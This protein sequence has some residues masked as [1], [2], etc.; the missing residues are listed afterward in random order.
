MAEPAVA[1]A[2]AGA[3]KKFPLAGA[4][5]K[6]SSVGSTTAGTAGPLG[7]PGGAAKKV[8][9]TTGVKA[10]MP[11]PRPGAP[12]GTI[13]GP[14][15]VGPKGPGANQPGGVGVAR[16]PNDPSNGQ[17]SAEGANGVEEG[18]NGVEYGVSAISIEVTADS[19]TASSSESYATSS[20]GST[21]ANG[22]EGATDAGAQLSASSPLPGGSS[23]GGDVYSQK[24][25]RSTV[26]VD[27]GAL[28][29]GPSTFT[30]QPGGAAAGSGNP[31]DYATPVNAQRRLEEAFADPMFSKVEITFKSKRDNAAYELLTTEQSYCRSLTVMNDLF[32]MPLLEACKRGLLPSV[33]EDMIHDIFSRYFTDIT[34]VNFVLLQGLVERFKDWS[35]HQFLGDLLL[36]LLPFLKMYTMYTSNYDRSMSALRELEGKNETVTKFLEEIN[37]NPLRSVDFR[38]YLIM[39]IQRIPRYRLLLE[40]LLKNTTPEHPDFESLSKALDS[41]KHVAIQIDAAI[42]EHKN[43][44]KL[45]E[46]QSS[47]VGEKVQIIEA[48]RVF[49]KEGELGKVCRKD[50]QKRNIWL[51]NDLFLYAKQLPPSSRYSKHRAFHLKSVRVKDIPDNGQLYKNAIQVASEKKSFILLCNTPE[52]KAS[53]MA[54]FA[55]AILDQETRIRVGNSDGP[56]TVAPVWV[57]DSEAVRCMI[58]GDK[59]TFTQRRH[60]CRQCGN[61]VCSKCSAKKKELPGQGKKRVC[62]SCY[63]KPYPDTTAPSPGPNSN[64]NPSPSPGGPPV[65]VGPITITNA[66]PISVPPTSTTTSLS[67]GNASGTPGSPT[68][69]STSPAPQGGQRPGEMY[70]AAYDYDPPV[71][72]PKK[73]LAFKAGD[74]MEI[75][76]KN[77]PGWWFAIMGETRGWVPAAFLEPV[78]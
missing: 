62:D 45:L 55:K 56:A 74:L 6:F 32:R 16:G 37:A 59:F 17:Q 43:R 65:S 20:I 48:G 23:G 12:K 31:E 44:D 4:A 9:V 77:D 27:F 67:P 63:T 30:L 25:F 76:I 2:P 19:S 46:I 18:Q 41:I 15:K 57:P 14:A 66:N 58:C 38:A 47:F 39:P 69:T 54:E 35:D 34:R 70:R 60:H 11:P 72:N 75:T 49:I 73:K 3:P 68:P 8:G 26:Q 61:V 53:W 78:V 71:E 7:V 42:V 51:F 52:E 10:P 22:A 40:E 5:K 21:Q 29:K 36:D 13:A 64:A 33:T 28:R 24:S 50:V 1:K